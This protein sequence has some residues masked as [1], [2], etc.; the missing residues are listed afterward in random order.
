MSIEGS[1]FEG[2]PEYEFHKMK[3]HTRKITKTALGL[4]NQIR[5]REH[6]SALERIAKDL[7]N[8]PQ[9][10]IQWEV[11]WDDYCEIT[12]YYVQIKKA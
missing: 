12:T 2:L 10:C 6:L 1:D 8:I 3:L 11:F 7:P 9:E 4:D 5:E